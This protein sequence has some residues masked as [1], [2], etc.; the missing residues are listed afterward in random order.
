[1]KVCFNLDKGNFKN[2]YYSSKCQFCI[3]RVI[4]VFIFSL[5]FYNVVQIT[6]FLSSET[7]PPQKKIG[8]N[9]RGLLNKLFL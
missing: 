2:K 4:N 6:L 8:K 3:D 7:P 5:K 1:M 9:N